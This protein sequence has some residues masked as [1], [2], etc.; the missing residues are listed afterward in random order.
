M[1]ILS[2]QVAR[3]VDIVR[4]FTPQSV[5]S[6][7]ACIAG[8]IEPPVGTCSAEFTVPDCLGTEIAPWGATYPRVRACFRCCLLAA[9]SRFRAQHAFWSEHL[10][11]H[12]RDPWASHTPIGLLLGVESRESILINAMSPMMLAHIG[13]TYAN[14]TLVESPRE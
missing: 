4:H 5:M 9:T 11:I 12:A 1:K 8:W 7:A 13:S 14:R 6:T 3:F 2:T 10:R